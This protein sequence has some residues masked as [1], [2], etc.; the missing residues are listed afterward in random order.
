MAEDDST[1]LLG[2]NGAAGLDLSVK[3]DKYKEEIDK[4]L[5]MKKRLLYFLD[6]D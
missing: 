6:N 4:I 1:M 2:E 3:F 5:G